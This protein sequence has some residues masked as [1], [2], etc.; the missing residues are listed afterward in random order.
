MWDYI[1]EIALGIFQFKAGNPLFL[2]KGSHTILVDELG[3]ELVSESGL[4]FLWN[5]ALL[6]LSLST[7]GFVLR[8]NLRVQ[9][10]NKMVRLSHSRGGGRVT[11]PPPPSGSHQKRP[12][13]QRE[14]TILS[15]S[16][17]Y[18]LSW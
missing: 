15:C 17:T 11:L 13:R 9:V 2:V 14:I 4:D 6:P 3:L 18:H 5:S 10:I 1:G 12:A 7:G 16:L 8:E